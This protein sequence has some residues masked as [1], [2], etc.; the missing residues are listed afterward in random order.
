M[1]DKNFYPDSSVT[2][3]FSCGQC[4]VSDKTRDQVNQEFL[5]S[6]YIRTSGTSEIGSGKKVKTYC[7]ITENSQINIAFN[8]KNT[9]G[10]PEYI[11]NTSNAYIDTGY[12]TPDNNFKMEVKY[13]ITEFTNW[14]QK[15]AGT[16]NN[17]TSLTCGRCLNSRNTE[18]ELGTNY[19]FDQIKSVN[20]DVYIS[21]LDIPS[22]T[23]TVSKV[24]DGTSQT[25]SFTTR[26]ISSTTMSDWYLFRGENLYP[27]PGKGKIYYVKMWHSDVLVRNFIPYI[28]QSSNEVGLFDL[29]EHKFYGSANSSKFVAGPTTTFDWKNIG[30]GFGNTIESISSW[31]GLDESAGNI[32]LDLQYGDSDLD[33][34]YIPLKFLSN[35]RLELRSGHIRLIEDDKNILLDKDDTSID[36]S[37]IDSMNNMLSLFCD[38][39]SNYLSPEIEVQGI[40]VYESGVKTLNAILVKDSI[41]TGFYDFNTGN[42][43]QLSL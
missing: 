28:N 42:Y 1:S 12:A 19:T 40:C 21:K 22:L 11:E 27:F 3:V 13:T 6:E 31:S 14:E 32:W 5:G 39:Y 35:Y 30:I 29:V 36:F 43:L 4:S 38:K 10:I 37:K 7:R 25:K 16:G 15:I 33:S 34:G 23:M 9:I 24:S 17:E 26:D 2:Q 18:W 8:I 41:S 20:G